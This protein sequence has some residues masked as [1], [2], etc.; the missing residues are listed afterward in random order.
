[1]TTTIPIPQ[2]PPQK[3]EPVEIKQDAVARS[4]ARPDACAKPATMGSPKGV[5]IRVNMSK[6]PKPRKR[7][8][9]YR[10]VNFY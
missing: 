10:D 4:M 3:K 8:K 2:Y 6:S 9:D 5:R 7:K 1:M